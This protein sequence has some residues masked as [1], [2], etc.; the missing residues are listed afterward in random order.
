EFRSGRGGGWMEG[1]AACRGIRD[2]GPV[3]STALEGR[4]A[5]PPYARPPLSKALWQGKDESM[6]WRGTADLGGVE[7]LLGRRILELDLGGHTAVDDR[8]EAH[9]YE[10]LLL[11]TGGR[12]RR[13]PAADGDVVYFRT[14]DDYRRV[15]DAAKEGARFLVIGGGF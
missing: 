13:L 3:G 8:G 7:L 4:E 6:V 14:L 2:R 12:P 5:A 1:D 9:R 15:R 10:R 11:A